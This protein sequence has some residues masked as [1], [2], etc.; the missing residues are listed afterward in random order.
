MEHATLIAYGNKFRYNEH[1]YDW[2]MLHEYGHEWWANLVTASDW[3]DFWIHEGF[4][5]YMDSL[6]LEHLGKK[7]LLDREKR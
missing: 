1:G 5:S 4:Q 7:A 2:L 3:R 6:Y